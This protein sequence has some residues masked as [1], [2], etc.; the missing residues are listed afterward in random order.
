VTGRKIAVIGSGISGLT[1]G[2]VLSR[3]DHVTPFEADRLL[4]GHDGSRPWSPGVG[5]R[6]SRS[7][8]APVR[9]TANL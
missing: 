3:T 2:Y 1:A 8:A 7:A 6:A 4:G 9:R 5:P